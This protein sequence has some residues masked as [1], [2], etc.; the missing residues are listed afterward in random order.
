MIGI[1]RR[2]MVGV[3]NDSKRKA[4]WVCLKALE[5]R[6]VSVWKQSKKELKNSNR[7]REIKISDDSTVV[8][9]NSVHIALISITRQL[10]KGECGTWIAL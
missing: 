10:I 8:Y 2:N 3:I 4:I 9:S 6:H 1:S 5:K 7:S